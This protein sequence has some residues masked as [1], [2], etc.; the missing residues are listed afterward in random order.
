MSSHHKSLELSDD[1]CLDQVFYESYN[2]DSDDSDDFGGDVD[3]DMMMELDDASAEEVEGNEE[4]TNVDFKLGIT[5]S[6]AD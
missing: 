5:R 4:G 2:M 3:T 6:Q 1:P